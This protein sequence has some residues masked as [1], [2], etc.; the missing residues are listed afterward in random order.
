[1][2]LK[3]IALAVMMTLPAAGFAMESLDDSA[4]SAAT[5]RDGITIESTL[6]ADIATIRYTDGAI[7]Q[8]GAGTVNLSGV[9]ISGGAADGGVAR[10]LLIDVNHGADGIDRLELTNGASVM[11]IKIDDIA[12]GHWDATLGHVTQGSVGSIAITGLSAAESVTKIWGHG[13]SS[14]GYN[15][16]TGNWEAGYTNADAS[17]NM[18]RTATD[19]LGAEGLAIQ[20]KKNIHIANV[21]WTDKDIDNAVMSNYGI[22]NVDKTAIGGSATNNL[23]AGVTLK[24]AG[25][26]GLG[27][28]NISDISVVDNMASLTFIDAIIDSD[29]KGKLALTKSAGNQDITIG[30]IYVGGIYQTTGGLQGKVIQAR[31]DFANHNA[32]L[33]VGKSLGAIQI[34]GLNMAGTQVKISAH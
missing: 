18:V 16:S 1:M 19:G 24:Q 11:N 26:A 31:A 9:H 20:S 27:T 25:M 6:K 12:M 33:E 21:A 23:P 14:Y 3:K 15:A 7:G 28:L 10:T 5:G 30:A 22:N 4:L 32:Y 34:L 17:L 13:A 8:D 29:G 2:Q